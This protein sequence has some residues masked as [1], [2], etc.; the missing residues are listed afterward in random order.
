MC[1]LD[2]GLVWFLTLCC[3]FCAFK[4]GIKCYQ[5][6]TAMFHICFAPGSESINLNIQYIPW[7]YSSFLTRIFFLFSFFQ[8]EIEQLKIF[9]L[10]I[11][12]G[13]CQI[14]VNL[15]ITIM[16]GLRFCSNENSRILK[17]NPI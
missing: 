7:S 15:L 2:F 11:A 13:N 5:N 17:I 6:R 4:V 12:A 9:F 10:F 14:N 3:H 1:C 16:V 8:W